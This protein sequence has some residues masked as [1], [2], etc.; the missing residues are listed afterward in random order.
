MKGSAW[1]PRARFLVLH[2]ALSTSPLVSC[3]SS[4]FLLLFDR[5]AEIFVAIFALTSP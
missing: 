2:R 3:E 4:A 1:S 5:P